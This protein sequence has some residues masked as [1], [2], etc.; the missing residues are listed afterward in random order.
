MPPRKLPASEISLL[1]ADVDGALVDGD[2]ALTAHARAAVAALDKC[3][4]AFA[5][6]S[7]RPPRGM[8][9]LIE[10]LHLKTFLAGF[11]GGML[12]RPDLTIVEEHRLDPVAARAA[13]DCILRNG[14]DVWVYSGNDWLVRDPGAPHVAREQR[15]VTFPP[16]V[17]GD[18]DGALGDAVKI[19]GV[20]DDRDVIAR[21]EKDAREA[22]GA[23]ASAS[24]SQ[25]YYLDITHPKANKGVVVDTLSDKLGIPAVEIATVGDM[26]NDIK[27]FEKSGLSIAMGNAPP[28]VKAAAHYVTDTNKEDGF[29]KAVERYVLS[30]AKNAAGS[31]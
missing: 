1:L 20:T 16:K 28:D 17:V 22:L 29:A 30:R 15:T 18:F 3:G 11:N 21:C 7:G 10:P 8:E 13:I 6:T 27:M 4:I 14:L 19:V 9:M 12:A 26:P 5:V 25:P 23:R 24:C 2:K 31:R